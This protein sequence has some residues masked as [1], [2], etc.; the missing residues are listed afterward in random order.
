MKG[1]VYCDIDG[2]VLDHRP[3]IRQWTRGW[4]LRRTVDPRAFSPEA[5]AGDL[6]AYGSL[7]AL[8]RIAERYEVHWV[9]ARPETLRDA[10][11]GWLDRHGY[12]VSSLTLVPTLDEKPSFL[13]ARPRVDLFVDDFLTGHE[14]PFLRLRRDV[15][16]SLE[17]RGIAYEVFHPRRNGWERI[18]RRLQV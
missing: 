9:T 6:P 7:E 12:P 5:V 17:E 2:T 18:A 13:A 16:R 8:R 14:G 4:L 11:R 15:I 3:R 1:A 10:T